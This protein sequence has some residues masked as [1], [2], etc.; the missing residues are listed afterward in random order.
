MQNKYSGR[1][2]SP[3]GTRGGHKPGGRALGGRARPHGL[4][5]PHALFGLLLIFLIFLNIP[6]RSKIAIGKVL[7]LVYLP[8]HIPIPFWSSGVFW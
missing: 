8:Y 6:K 3:E 7:E 1:K 5:P 2:R 4:S